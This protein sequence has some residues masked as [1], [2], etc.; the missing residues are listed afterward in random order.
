MNY[1]SAKQLSASGFAH[2]TSAVGS[3]DTVL[4]T[5]GKIAP[6][7]A[8]RQFTNNLENT[9]R[10]LH[11]H[12]GNIYGGVEAMLLT[13][14]RQRNL[15]PDLQISFALCFDGRFSEELRAEGATVQPLGNV[16]ARQPLSIRRGRRNLKD[17]LRQEAF[18]VV[19]THSCWSQAIFGPTV[20]AA[21][22]PLV[23]Y[24]HSPVNGKHWLERWARRTP[25]DM[26]IGNSNFTAA[27][28]SQLY[29]G[30]RAETVYCPVAPAE[31]GQLAAD[32]SATRAEWQTPEDVVVIIQVSRMEAWK[33]HALLLE[34]LSLLRDLP[35]WLCWQ[36]GG[37]QRP[38]EIQ[39]RDE[40]NR[41]AGRLGISERVHFLDQRTDV[42]RLLEAADI[43]CQPNLKPEP[44]GIV[45]I[46][47]LY[48][49]LP[50]VTTDI[51]GALEIIDDSCGMLVPPGDAGALA[52]SLRRLI[53][54]QTERRRFGT[55][56]PARA[57]RICDPASQLRQFHEALRSVIRRQQVSE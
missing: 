8:A 21:S 32:R 19:V 39:Y 7:G 43:F 28:S 24:M 12:A 1:S 29:P 55:R 31:H 18:D 30:V 57:R 5:S 42:T 45:F 41:I 50:I 53:T 4:D 6:A 36:V 13:Q 10:V 35:D 52:E 14:I 25:P 49:Q 11:V 51:G 34:A 3:G 46:E 40:L 33:G 44:F 2:S 9:I 47:A 16:R 56:G 15:C 23:F 26:V 48:A 22:V 37:A 27:T 54:D 38:T 17:L 20:R